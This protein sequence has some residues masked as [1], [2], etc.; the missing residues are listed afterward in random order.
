MVMVASGLE[1]DG[2]ENFTPPS[3]GMTN[4]ERA[5][6]SVRVMVPGLLIGSRWSYGE[7]LKCCAPVDHITS[8]LGDICRTFAL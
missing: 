8:W 5:D 3:L 6:V 7:N 2:M 1:P 4:S